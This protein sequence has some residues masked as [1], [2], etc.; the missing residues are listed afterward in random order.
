MK[1]SGDASAACLAKI[2]SNVEAVRVVEAFQR[3]L[4][5]LR[6]VHQLMRGCGGQERETIKM[7]VWH[8]HYVAGGVRVCVQADKAMLAAQNETAGGFS[9]SRFHAVGDGIVNG[10]DQVA[11][12]AMVVAGPGRKARRNAGPCGIVRRCDVGIAPGSKELIHRWV[13]V[14]NSIEGLS[15]A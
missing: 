6:Q 11:E 9:F 7:S 12:D 5:P 10:G 4:S 2:H 3:L 1:V 8:H 14:C 13:S 15:G